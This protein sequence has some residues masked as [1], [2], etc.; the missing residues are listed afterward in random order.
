MKKYD[1]S[2]GVRRRSGK[3]SS[4]RRHCH[5][6]ACCRDKLGQIRSRI[7][8]RTRWTCCNRAC[9]LCHALSAAAR[10]RK[11]RSKSASSWPI[12]ASSPTRRRKV[13]MASSSISSSTATRVGGRE[14]EII[15]KDTGGINPP[16]VAKRL[17][18]ELIVR[19]NVDILAGFQL[20]PNALAAA[21]VSAQAKKFMVVMNAG[22]SIITT[23]SPYMAR[24]SFTR[25]AA[26]RDAR[27][28][29]R[30]SDGLEKR[31]HAWSPTTARASTPRPRSTKASRRPAA[32]SSARCAMAVQNPDFSAYVQRAKDLNPKAI[33]IMIPGGAQPAAFGKALGRTRHRPAEDRGTGPG[34][35]SPTN[36]R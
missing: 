10:K 26:Q 21:D 7:M 12:P 17:A 6:R 32:R 4:G 34:A 13:T 30:P 31:L 5:L 24:V 29:G 18:Q 23:K 22:T 35:N 36:M 14:V 8:R 9:A 19:D 11:T 28:P 1:R 15:R 3:R 16:D 27:R 20:T 33:F 2:C 25:A